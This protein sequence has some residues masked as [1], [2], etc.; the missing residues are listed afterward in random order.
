MSSTALDAASYYYQYKLAVYENLFVGIV[1]GAYIVL[2]VT[3][4]YVLLRE[5]G[6]TSSPPRMF[7]FGTTTFMFILGIIIL[8]LQTTLEFQ[9]MQLLV[10]PTAPGLWSSYRTNV[11]IAVGATA[12]RLMYILSDIICS[13]RAVVIWNRDKRVIAILLLFILGTTAAAGCELGLNLRPLFDPSYQS[14]EDESNVKIGELAL[15]MG[16][17]TLA[18]NLLSTGLIAWK[19]WKR[20]ISVRKHLCGGSGPVRVDRLFALLIESGF[21][22]CCIWACPTFILAEGFTELLQILFVISAFQGLS[23][24]G[25]VIIDSVLLCQFISG[26]YPT[27]IVTLVAMQRSPVEHFS[28][29]PTGEQLPAF[30]PSKD[31]IRRPMFTI[32]REYASDSDTLIPSS[33]F[34][35]FS[36]EEKSL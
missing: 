24:L 18:T 3:S 28:T 35:K 31:S 1:Y 29:H 7:M 34:M 25:I 16:G 12:T 2:Y 21:I 19:A 13:W 9:Q 30:G 22:Y 6:F 14:L 17:P 23:Y 20:R 27:L 8:A 33:V 11:V 4:G 26:L 36:D 15:I 10:N 5:P 32:H